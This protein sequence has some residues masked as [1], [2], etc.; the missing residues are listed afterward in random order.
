ML[1]EKE[2]GMDRISPSGL[3]CYEECPKLFYYRNYL[4]LKITEGSRHFEFGTAIHSALEN[5]YLQY[6]DN[7]GGAWESANKEE[8]IKE[9]TNVWKVSSIGDEEF[10]DYLKSKKGKDSGFTHKKE[11]YQYMRAD[12]IAM[13]NEYWDT[14]ELLI[15]KHGIDVAETELYMRVQMIN[16]ADPTDKLPIP[17]SLRIDAI[18]RERVGAG[19]FKTSGAKYNEQEAREKIQGLCYVYAL[20]SEDQIVRPFDY[21]VLRKDM[22]TDGGRIQVV[23][24]D[25]E[26]AD[27]D[28]WYQRV[29]AILQRIANK[30]FAAPL[31]GHKPWCDCR[32]FDELL[33]VS[34]VK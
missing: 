25:Y 26:Q 19:D 22:K 5:L 21:I 17:L 20:Y 4:G 32:K 10:L 34:N 1:T 30:E 11:L 9:F 6:D 16:P 13:L 31:S 23:N 29:K 2:I 27:V 3:D 18:Y 24:L 33:D 7:F 15:T 8:Y 28:A 12:G 14:K